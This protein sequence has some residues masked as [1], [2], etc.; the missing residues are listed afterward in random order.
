[1]A[2]N[3]SA[4]CSIDLNI[5][6]YYINISAREMFTK[7]AQIFYAHGCATPTKRK[8]C[9]DDDVDA[10]GCH[11]TEIIQFMLGSNSWMV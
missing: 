7:R 2:S 8:K 11:V 1:M 6:G 9:D 3:H 5:T 10:Q 4:L